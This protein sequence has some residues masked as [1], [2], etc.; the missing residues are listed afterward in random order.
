MLVCVDSCRVSLRH[1]T[2]GCAEGDDVRL[3][4][5]RSGHAM[6]LSRL[7][8]FSFSAGG[9]EVSALKDLWGLSS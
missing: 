1:G 3:P 2:Q 7:F 6:F 9:V 4:R 8:L 5:R